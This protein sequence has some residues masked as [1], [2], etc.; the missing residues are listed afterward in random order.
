MSLI[1]INRIFIH[2]FSLRGVTIGGIIILFISLRLT[3]I[4][5]KTILLWIL[6]IPITAGVAICYAS[7]VSEISNQLEKARQG[8]IM[9]IVNSLLALAFAI[10][11]VFVGLLFYMSQVLPIIVAALLIGLGY[12]LLTWQELSS[13]KPKI[14]TI[15]EQ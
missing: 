13:K 6:I 3:M 11:G 1:F 2:T 5:Y 12:L 7:L 8:F 14:S 15:I 9:G 10:T 4:F